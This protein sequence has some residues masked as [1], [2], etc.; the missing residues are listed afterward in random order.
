A[1]V[2]TRPGPIGWGLEM[3]GK[4]WQQALVVLTLA[5]MVAFFVN[6]TGLAAAAPV[7]LFAMSGMAYPAFVAATRGGAVDRSSQGGTGG[8]GNE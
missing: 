3:A 4:R 2:L 8:E 7:F 6:D 5:G 1:L